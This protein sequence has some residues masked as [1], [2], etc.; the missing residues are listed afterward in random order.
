METERFVPLPDRGVTVCV[1][2]GGNG[3]NAITQRPV[4]VLN[5]TRSDL[6]NQ[7]NALSWPVA[8]SFEVMVH[9]HRGLGRSEQDVE[10]Y[11]PNMADFALDALALCDAEEIGEFDVISTSFGG[12]IAQELAIMAGDRVRSLVLSCTSSGG[13]GGSSYPLHELYESG[14][15]LEDLDDRWDTRTTTD[16][17]VAAA[18]TRILGEPRN[19]IE[20]TPGLLRQLEARRHHDTWDRLDQI[21]AR[22]LVAFGEF[23]GIA[24]PQNSTRLAQRIPGAELAE[25]SGGHMFM[26]QDRTAWP[27]VLEFLVN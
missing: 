15:T 22:T 27:H 11:Q 10:D 25:F 2:R 12:M 9:D 24:P 18:M 19:R 7:P 5:G 14:H 8:K 23:D 4:L 3:P 16:P 21:T 13:G 26:W 20:P 17:K 1:A 6:R